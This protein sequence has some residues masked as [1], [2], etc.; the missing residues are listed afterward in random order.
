MGCGASSNLPSNRNFNPNKPTGIPGSL[1]QRIHR[2][3]DGHER[4]AKVSFSLTKFNI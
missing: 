2:G 3:P 4:L 1:E